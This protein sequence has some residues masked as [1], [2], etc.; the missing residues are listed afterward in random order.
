MTTQNE[1]THKFADGTEIVIRL[2]DDE[3]QVYSDRSL[4]F[5]RHKDVSVLA[6]LQSKISLYINKEF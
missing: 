3:I 4:S 5:E 6:N 1:I 2:F